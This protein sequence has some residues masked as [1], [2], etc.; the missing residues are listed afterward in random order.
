[1]SSSVPGR[2]FL[3]DENVRVELGRWLRSAGYDVHEA[4]RATGDAVVA[5]QA[6]RDHHILVTNDEDF[7]AFSQDEIYAVI[8]LRIPQNDPQALLRSFQKL[9]A[10]CAQFA[11]QL[12]LLR[13][14][15]WRAVPLLRR[16][17]FK[18]K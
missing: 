16:I 17:R 9:L 8:W 18:I 14:D 10:E 13:V 15:A 12:I 5:A 11:G 1:M 3:L 2:R 7:C 4:S 6:L